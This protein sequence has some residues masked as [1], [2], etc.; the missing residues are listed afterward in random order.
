MAKHVFVRP[1]RPADKDKFVEWTLGTKNNLFDA[2]VLTYPNSYTRCAFNQNGPIAFI[3]VQRPLMLEWLAI[4]P[5][6]DKLEVAIALRELVQDAVSQAYQQG[7]GEIYF[8]CNEPTTEKLA[9]ANGFEKIPVSVYRMKLSDLER[10]SHDTNV[11][12]PGLPQ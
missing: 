1:A 2:G 11:E 9:A 6:A 12:K 10:P 8:L 3:P 4:N 7:S 5:E